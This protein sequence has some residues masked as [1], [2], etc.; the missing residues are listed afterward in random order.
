MTF[1]LHLC[2]EYHVESGMSAY[3]GSTLCLEFDHGKS[4]LCL[5]FNVCRED[6]VNRYC[7]GVRCMS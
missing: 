6:M 2:M 4:T 1:A 5:V 7:V 3:L